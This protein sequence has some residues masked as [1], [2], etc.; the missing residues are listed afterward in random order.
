M[1]LE[2]IFVSS[3]TNFQTCF[4]EAADSKVGWLE[5]SGRIWRATQ[6]IV[7]FFERDTGYSLY[8]WEYK[9]SK[10]ATICNVCE[11]VTT[12]GKI[13]YLTI[14]HLTSSSLV[15]LLEFNRLIKVIELPVKITCISFFNHSTS[16]THLP[17]GSF[18]GILAFGCH[19]GQ[20]FTMD[21][22]LD[23]AMEKSFK[24]FVP[25]PIKEILP[26]DS[27]KVAR[28]LLRDGIHVIFNLNSKKPY[29]YLECWW[30]A[31][32]QV[33]TCNGNHFLEMSN[34]LVTSCPWL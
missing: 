25:S 30:D 8:C 13:Y 18:H 32:N 12:R 9:P 33:S 28:Q 22:Q 6:N 19:G 34:F 3:L 7:E 10:S 31:V 20:V 24:T 1:S 15:C 26:K 29:N 16:L 4:P 2:S 17:L 11:C 23:I 27:S 14:V 5:K 21:L